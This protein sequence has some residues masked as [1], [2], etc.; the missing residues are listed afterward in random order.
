M[1]KI[2]LSL[3]ALLALTACTEDKSVSFPPTFADMVF[4]NEAG[5][6]IDRVHPGDKFTATMTMAKASQ[7]VPNP[8]HNWILG[9]GENKVGSSEKV[10]VGGNMPCATFTV[11]ADM[12]AGKYNV[13]VALKY[14]IAGN[15]SLQMPDYK[16]QSGLTVAYQKNWA[17]VV[18]TYELTCTKSI[19]VEEAPAPTE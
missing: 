1:K 2:L 13:Q 12:P 14:A 4:T 3:I 15:T 10:L 11:P 8:K 16:T 7:N 18:G 5:V 9:S 6:A 17:G 19:I